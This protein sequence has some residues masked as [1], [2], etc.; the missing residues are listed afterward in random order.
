MSGPSRSPSPSKIP[1]RRRLRTG[2]IR[3]RSSEWRRS[4]PGSTHGVD[5]SAIDYLP[6]PQVI[7]T[8]GLCECTAV[9]IASASCSLVAQLTEIE[10]EQEFEGKFNPKLKAKT[11]EHQGARAYVEAYVVLTTNLKAPSQPLYP[12]QLMMRW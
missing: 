8:D 12:N 5:T 1:S 9:I 3:R 10:S 11:T 4:P 6:A 2:D 7:G